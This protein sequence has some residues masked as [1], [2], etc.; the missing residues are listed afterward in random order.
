MPNISAVPGP[1]KLYGKEFRELFIAPNNRVFVGTDLKGIELRTLSHYLFPYDG[2][3]YATQLLSGDIHTANQ[4]AAGL[5]TRDTAK[6]FIFAHN[7]G[8]GDE[9]L[10][11]IINPTACADEQKQLG[12]Q[13]RDNFLLKMPGINNL[14]ADVKHTFNVRGF[15]TGLDGR[16]LIPRASY[17]AFN[18]LLQGAGAIIAKKWTCLINDK[19]KDTNILQHIHSHDEI[20]FSC[21]ETEAEMLM[22]ICEDSALE[23]GVFFKLNIPIEASAKIGQT[24]YEVH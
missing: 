16:K 1:K 7:Y 22:K 17:S 9:K 2:G 20:L 3:N 24:W 4:E 12:R 11:A 21:H 5:P 14:I 18:T 8:A 23:T 19:I 6:R 15:L 13:A 10:G